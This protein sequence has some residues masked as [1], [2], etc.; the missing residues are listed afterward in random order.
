MEPEEVGVLALLQVAAVA[1]EE[2]QGVAE[3]LAAPVTTLEVVARLVVF[4]VAAAPR[5]NITLQAGVLVALAQFVSSGPETLVA[6][7]QLAPAIFDLEK[8]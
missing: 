1:L 8:S 4:T 6:S 7:H 3:T 2:P 5:V